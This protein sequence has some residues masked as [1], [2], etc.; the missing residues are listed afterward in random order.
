[1]CGLDLGSVTAGGDHRTQRITA[2][3]PPTRTNNRIVVPKLYDEPVR[4]STSMFTSLSGGD[5]LIEGHVIIGPTMARSGYAFSSDGTLDTASIRLTPIA[6][7]HEDTV[8]FEESRYREGTAPRTTSYRVRSDGFM[9]RQNNVIGNQWETTGVASGFGLVKAMVLISKTRTYDTFL[10]N[11]RGGVL[12]TV[13]IPTTSPMKPVVKRVRASTWQ[14]FEFLIAQKC[15][16]QGTLLLGV[17]KDTQS[18]FLYA[19]GHANGTATV[20]QP[21]GRVPGAFNDPAY[22]RFT[23][24]VDPL[25]GE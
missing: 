23:P 2:G 22:F 3:S 20:I 5:P 11:T 25:A 16:N 12:S 14:G 7:G 1:M 15:G 19:V 4:L 21:L 13:R 9:V 18:A 6:G 10:A 24:L 8:A 17:D